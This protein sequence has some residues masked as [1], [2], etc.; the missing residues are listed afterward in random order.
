MGIIQHEM[1]HLEGIIMLPRQRKDRDYNSSNNIEY[2]YANF[3]IGEARDELERVSDLYTK[4]Q[5]ALDI[6]NNRD[7]LNVDF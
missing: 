4:A 3:N 6:V 7:V 5:T 1:D 2:V